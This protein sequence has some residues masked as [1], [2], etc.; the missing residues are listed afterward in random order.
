MEKPA[1]GTK[2]FIMFDV[3]GVPFFRVYT[4]PGS[5]AYI[6]YDILHS[7]LEVEILDEFAVFRETENGHGPSLD[8]S[9][10]VLG[11]GGDDEQD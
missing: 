8:Y 11:R 5:G 7:D 9:D 1:K 4:A 3:D 10:R 2:G 6:D